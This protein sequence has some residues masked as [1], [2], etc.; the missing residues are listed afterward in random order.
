MNSFYSVSS[1]GNKQQ[2][3]KALLRKEEKIM[4]NF[5]HE[6]YCPYS[7]V[8]LT[9]NENTDNR[10][11]GLWSLVGASI[12]YEK[13]EHKC[14]PDI[15]ACDELF[16]TDVIAYD[17]LSAIIEKDVTAHKIKVRQ[18]HNEACNTQKKSDIQMAMGRVINPKL[19]VHA[20]SNFAVV[21]ADAEYGMDVW[22]WD[23]RISE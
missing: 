5:E 9:W 2:R 6:G 18:L 15:A 7:N 12:V 16:S 4:A 10:L 13:E 21:L 19:V 1:V 14:T 20:G 11:F 23:L 17:V 8:Q 22:V 3:K